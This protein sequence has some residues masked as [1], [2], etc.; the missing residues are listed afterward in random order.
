[1]LRPW[2]VFRE[3]TVQH[4]LRYKYINIQEVSTSCNAVALCFSFRILAWSLGDCSGSIRLHSWSACICQCQLTTCMSC[5]YRHATRLPMLIKVWW[6]YIRT[7]KCKLV[8]NTFISLVLRHSAMKRTCFEG[9]T[10]GLC[11]A[12]VQF[13]V[14]ARHFAFLY[15][16]LKTSKF[17]FTHYSRKQWLVLCE[18]RLCY[19]PN[20][21]AERLIC[22][23]KTW[24]T[25]WC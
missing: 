8:C 17:S 6:I 12:R 20:P 10:I 25:H 16:L 3:T 18:L 22:K 7:Y 21:K 1:M 14:T 19:N 23:M 24:C 15:F 4:H 13:P 2:A 11:A 9:L 5:L